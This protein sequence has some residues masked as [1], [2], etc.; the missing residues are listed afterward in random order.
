MADLEH[1][2]ARL[3]DR[4]RIGVPYR[5]AAEEQA[6]NKGEIQP[7]LDAVAEAGGEAVPVSLLLSPAERARRCGELDGFLLPGS[8][9]DVAPAL[10]NQARAPESADPDPRREETDIA[11]LDDAFRSGKPVLGICYGT[12]LLNVYRGGTLVQDIPAE[13]HA[14]LKH[15]WAKSSG[16]P[17]PHHPARFVP[18][19][20]IA[21][22]AEASEAVVNSSHHQSIREPGRGLRVTAISPDGIVE[23][24]EWGGEPW[25]VGVQWHPERERIQAETGG[26]RLARALFERLV[27]KAREW[28][29]AGKSNRQ[30][31]PDTA[32]AA[33]AAIHEK[34]EER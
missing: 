29:E 3:P 18:G 1:Q 14:A 26:G 13:L 34:V 30:S 5:R 4:P 17:E 10:Y 22:L 8:P 21:R 25:V 6:G 24:V 12:Q 33:A 28:R 23:A 7:Y 20:E 27:C 9:A 2:K 32:S 16:E 15:S 11:L 31:L 19:T